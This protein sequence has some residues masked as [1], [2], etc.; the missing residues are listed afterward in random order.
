MV[1]VGIEAQRDVGV[2]ALQMNVGQAVEGGLHLNGII[3]TNP[4]AHG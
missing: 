1:E 2:G 4:G 3:L